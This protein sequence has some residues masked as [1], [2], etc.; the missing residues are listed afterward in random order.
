GKLIID[1]INDARVQEYPR[2][3]DV[4]RNNGKSP[5]REARDRLS[6]L[7]LWRRQKSEQLNLPI[8]VV[9][10]ANLL[11]ILAAKPPADL[12]ALAG[13]AGIRRWRVKEF[14]AEIMRAIQETAAGN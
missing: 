12:A 5:T 7:K 14:G 13:V 11:E 4:C 9:F 6:M 2:I 1:T 8:G 3:N 10:P